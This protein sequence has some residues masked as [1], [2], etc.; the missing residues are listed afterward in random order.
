MIETTAVLGLSQEQ[1]QEVLVAATRAPSLHNTQPWSFR[2]AGEAIE[3]YADRSRQL[4]VAD[5]SGRE[6]R[7]A[8]GAAL[9]NLRL[10]LLGL[11]IKPLV[12]SAT[13]LL[14]TGQTILVLGFMACLSVW[15]GPRWRADG[16]TEQRPCPVERRRPLAGP[17]F[18]LPARPACHH[19]GHSAVGASS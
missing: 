10:A 12:V 19:S 3:L 7:I 14:H 16:R 18:L 6:L 13:T 1:L 8:C 15:P 2:L 4:P 11:G 17:A 5:P 9:F